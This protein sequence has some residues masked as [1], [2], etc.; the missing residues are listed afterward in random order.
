MKFSRPKP[1]SHGRRRLS[2]RVMFLQ[3]TAR[4][5]A[6]I[7]A[8]SN[9]ALFDLLRITCFIK[10]DRNLTGM[11]ASILSALRCVSVSFLCVD[12]PVREI[13]HQAGLAIHLPCFRSSRSYLLGTYNGHGPCLFLRH[14]YRGWSHR[15]SAAASATAPPR[16]IP[17]V[18]RCPKL[19]VGG[20]G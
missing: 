19:S 6:S 4:T 3:E 12:V 1:L 5:N 8:A 18:I 7:F 17:G 11:A 9:C 10:I 14:L 15:S 13:L 20:S 16:V 2:T